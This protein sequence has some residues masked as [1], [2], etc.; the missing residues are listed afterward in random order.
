MPVDK[1]DI[2]E[3]NKLLSDLQD[4][5]KGVNAK[6]KSYD[7]KFEASDSDTKAKI[8][9]IQAELDAKDALLQK[10]T[11]A[12]DAATKKE[13]SKEM[14]IED[15]NKLLKN[16]ELEAKH[17]EILD[18]IKTIE[19]SMAKVNVTD[20]SKKAYVNGDHYKALKSYLLNG[21]EEGIANFTKTL[22]TNIGSNGGYL[23]P[24]E[25]YA[26][27]LEEM[28]E[29]NPIRPLARLFSVTAKTLEV[30]IRTTLP[31][32]SYEG[33]L[34]EASDS[35]STYRIESMTAYRQ[36]INTPV[37]WDLINFS[38]NDIIQQMSKDAAMGFAVN[39]GTRFL[40]GTGVKQPEGILTNADVL[41]GVVTSAAAGVVSL[42]DV[43]PLPGNLKTGYL[44][45]SRFFMSQATLYDLRAEQD[46]NGNF[47]W[48]IGGEGMPNNIAGLP[49]VILPGMPAVA[50]SS[51][52]VG[53][54]NFFYGYYILDA[55]GVTMIKDEF[56]R[57]KE[58]VVEVTWHKWN[59]G[60]VGIPEAFQLLQ[61]HA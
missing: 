25:L 45:G 15:L 23:V 53:V 43:V 20:K 3:T 48:R 57:K 9:K 36:H 60:Q 27:I 19:T 37:T 39:E 61:T 10:E 6:L 58:A 35:N 59:T 18:R 2:Q 56:S 44:A 8:K 24:V 28:E 12:K 41:A 21:D 5:L 17:S 4:S 30:P 32:A 16:T 51:Y 31:T 46:E 52:S 1:T 38:Q 34:E 55:V 14:E 22:S 26:Q 33:E 47:L 7:E 49:Y 50:A 11:I 29:V 13:L 40:T 42:T 54:G